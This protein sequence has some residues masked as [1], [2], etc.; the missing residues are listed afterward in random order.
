MWALCRSAVQARQLPVLPHTCGRRPARRRIPQRCQAAEPPAAAQQS[1][2]VPFSDD[3]LRRLSDNAAEAED[4]ALAEEWMDGFSGDLDG[5]Y[6]Y[7]DR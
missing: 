1:P 4:V 2:P 3:D 6:D 5:L 7:V